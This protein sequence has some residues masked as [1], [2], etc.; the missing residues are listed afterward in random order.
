MLAT[1]DSAE[2]LDADEDPAPVPFQ[3]LSPKA[4]ERAIDKHRYNDVE[5]D[6]WDFAYEDANRMAMLL[7]IDIDVHPSKDRAG[8]GPKIYFS[9]FCSQGDGASFTGWYR[10]KSDA[11]ECIKAECDDETLISL[12]ERLT[13]MNVRLALF[14]GFERL[15]TKITTSGNYSHSGTMQC[16]TEFEPFGIELEAGFPFTDIDD[17]ITVCMREFA[18]WIYAQLEAEYDH[19][20]SDETVKKRLTEGDYLFN[21][22]GDMI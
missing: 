12:A 15:Q 8:T 11:L 3:A 21:E 17:E 22:D 16:S 9:G 14:E 19:L 4:Q 5:H 10:P 7:G 6:W 18:D 1:A 2:D 13:V 20:T